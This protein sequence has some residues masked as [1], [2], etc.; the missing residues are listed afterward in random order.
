MRC[1]IKFLSYSDVEIS[2]CFYAHVLR[3]ASQPL[4]LKADLSR[5]VE[6]VFFEVRLIFWPPDF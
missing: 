5:Y 2:R 3:A 6:M 1:Q 4:V